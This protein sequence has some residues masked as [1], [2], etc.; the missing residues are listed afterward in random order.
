[1]SKSIVLR[2]PGTAAGSERQLKLNRIG[3]GCE[4]SCRRLATETSRLKRS[5]SVD[6]ATALSKITSPTR[7]A[8]LDG[9]HQPLVQIWPDDDPVHEHE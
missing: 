8:D 7:E 9:I 2:S 4:N 3:S 5:R 1:M 6:P